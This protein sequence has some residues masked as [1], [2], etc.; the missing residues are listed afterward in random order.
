MSISELPLFILIVIVLISFVGLVWSADRFVAGAAAIANNMGVAPIIIGLTIV[1]IGTSAPEILVSGAAA[2]RDASSLAVGNALGS[3]LANIGLVLGITALIAPLPVTHSI[4][5]REFLFMIV[6]TAIA[7]WVLYDNQLLRLEST[8]L[9][10]LLVAFLSYTIIQAKRGQI[11][12]DELD[13]I[14]DGLSNKVA[15]FWI[16]IGLT[17]LLICSNFLVSSA[18]EI[19]RVMGV[20]EMIIGVTM[21][22]VGTSIPE[23]AASVASARKGHTDIAVGNIIGSNIFNLLAVLPVA[24]LIGPG[25]IA[26]NNFFRDFGATFGICL[27]LGMLCLLQ[28]RPNTTNNIKLFRKS[29]VILCLLYGSYYV[30]LF[31]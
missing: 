29:G 24:G 3:N 28:C 31:V 20:S 17:V 6:I 16:I 19:A 7:G 18:T 5:K 1:S 4:L 8:A 21:V 2:M 15:I 23:L 12:V 27:F 26:E 14:P 9:L 13:D 10:L 22:A 11:R 25:V 30:W